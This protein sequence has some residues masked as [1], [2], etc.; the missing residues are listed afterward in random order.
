MGKIT[1][2]GPLW[3]GLNKKFC[4]RNYNTFNTSLRNLGFNTRLS[5][6]RG[7]RA[8]SPLQTTHYRNGICRGVW[9]EFA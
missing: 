7:F 4:S 1:L 8:H 3:T 2:F 5:F 6:N 9:A